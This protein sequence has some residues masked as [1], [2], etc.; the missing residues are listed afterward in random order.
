MGRLVLPT[1]LILAVAL[2]GCFGS[3][4][5]PVKVINPPFTYSRSTP[6]AVLTSLIHAYE[7]RDSVEYAKLYA[8][9]YQGASYDT[10]EA[11]GIQ[12]GTFTRADEVAHI[13]ALAEDARVL[14]VSMDLGPAGSW[15]RTVVPGPNNDWTEIAIYNPRLEINE[16]GGGGYNI[17]SSEIFTFVFSPETPAA[18]SS[19]DTLWSIERWFEDGPSGP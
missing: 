5:N 8:Y 4:K 13:K 6:Q 9:D 17:A 2:A 10:S 16:S 3:K 19:T 12:P 7:S 15:T 18:S 11:P 1:L 14:G